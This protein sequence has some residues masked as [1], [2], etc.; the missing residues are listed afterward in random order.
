MNRII[1]KGN[2]GDP[3]L[4]DTDSVVAIESNCLVTIYDLNGEV[5]GYGCYVYLAGGSKIEVPK[6]FEDLVA[7]LFG[8]DLVDDDESY[9]ESDADLN[10]KA[11]S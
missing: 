10:N 8:C 7:A 2:F 5:D 4:I 9:H 6:D 1:I 3:I 11:E